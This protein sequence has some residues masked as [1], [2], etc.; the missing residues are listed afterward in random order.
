MASSGYRADLNVAQELVKRLA[1][2]RN[3]PVEILLPGGKKP[4]GPDPPDK[5]AIIP[6]KPGLEEVRSY[7]Q[8]GDLVVV[9][10][11]VLQRWIGS[12]ALE[13]SEAG[14]SVTLV[15]AASPYRLNLTAASAGKKTESIMSLGATN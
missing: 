14:R 8:P 3:L 1:R 12:A 4:A 11:A 13:F 9:P 15:I 10:I 5:A 6:I 7:A 2:S